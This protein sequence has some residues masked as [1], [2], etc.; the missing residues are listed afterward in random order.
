MTAI[1]RAI[2]VLNVHC[3]VE[4]AEV[5]NRPASVG[6][7]VDSLTRWPLSSR[8]FELR[9][10]HA[11][12]GKLSALMDRFRDHT[13]ALFEKHGIPLIGFWTPVDADGITSGPD[14][15]VY[16][17]AFE[18]RAAANAAWS[19]FRDDPA[20]IKARD[21]SEQQWQAGDGLR[22]RLPRTH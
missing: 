12:P 2:K 17:L 10:Y 5:T 22:I 13:L 6:A 21:E 7:A 3:R 11:E 15:L 9:T 1:D 20:W 19:A 8:V 18:D 16:L 14:T 4:P